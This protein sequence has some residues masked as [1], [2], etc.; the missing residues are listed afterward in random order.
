MFVEHIETAALFHNDGMVRAGED[1]E[2]VTECPGAGGGVFAGCVPGNIKDQG[3]Q[4]ERFCVGSSRAGAAGSEGDEDMG[5]VEPEEARACG[6][7]V[8][9]EERAVD[10]EKS[11]GNSVGFERNDGWFG[12]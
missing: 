7:V 5:C 6:V 11:F 9:A 2:G 8:K 3:A 10:R 12:K 1:A 4:C